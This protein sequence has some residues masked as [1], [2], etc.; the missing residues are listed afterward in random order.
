MLHP[1][2]LANHAGMRQNG[3]RNATSL[4]VRAPGEARLPWSTRHVNTRNLRIFL[5][6]MHWGAAGPA[7]RTSGIKPAAILYA[8]RRLEEALGVN[9]F[10]R[11]PPEMVPTCAA[12]RL[13]PCALRFLAMWDD[14]MADVHHN[15]LGQA[16]AETLSP[17]V[18]SSTA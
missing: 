17:S 9:L 1:V 14:V 4:P 5:L 3:R 18:V 13:Y 12:Q 10:R 7:S 6:V 16:D 8:I 15:A 11:R 2:D